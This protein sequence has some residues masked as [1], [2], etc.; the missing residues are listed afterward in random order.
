MVLGFT[1]K[2][3]LIYGTPVLTCVFLL[4]MIRRRPRL[5]HTCRIGTRTIFLVHGI[6]LCLLVTLT[7]I[8]VHDGVRPFAWFLVVTSLFV[9]SVLLGS[10]NTRATWAILFLTVL[11]TAISI[12]VAIYAGNGFYP[13]TWESE[14]IFETGTLQAYQE[15][16]VRAGLYYFVPI[17]T[18]N[19]AAIAF[20][21]GSISFVSMILSATYLAVIASAIFILFRRLHSS[22][23]VVVA[24]A[25]LFFSIPAL[26]V[27]G[28][29]GIFSYAL[30]FMWF[31]LA[32]CRSPLSAFIGILLVGIV[33]IFW[34]PLSIA[35]VI[36]MLLPL[37]ILRIKDWP[38]PGK[39]SKEIAN[40]LLVT[41]VIAF[42][43]WTYTYLLNLGV[44][45]G[46]SFYGTIQSYFAGPAAAGGGEAYVPRYSFSGLEVFAYAWSV[47]I[48]LSVAYF[49]TSLFI[50]LRHR[51]V[52]SE[53][54]T[55]FTS[56]LGPAIVLI[57]Y[58]SYSAGEAG[59]Y[60]IPVGYMVTLLAASACVGVLLAKPGKARR[61]VVLTLI[62]S[63]VLVG[64]Y[65]PDWAPLEHP[66]FESAS[67]LHPYHVYIEAETVSAFLP[68]NVTVYYDYDFPLSGHLYKP[69][70]EVIE[71]VSSGADPVIYASPLSTF[72]G[73]RTER[74]QSVPDW[75][76][77]V[78]YSS[79]FHVVT[80]VNTK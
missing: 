70:R 8:S 7:A 63:V 68:L 75:N 72:F 39:N 4:L 59:Q 31:V 38:I 5:E 56:F 32:K 57:S 42:A 77:D 35:Y 15:G 28:R 27:F 73:M 41:L 26:S 50:L 46:T 36:A 79:G 10:R 23:V 51:R 74:L 11:T 40:P 45:M 78:I 49:L 14:P 64:T 48:A 29:A 53:R 43:Y 44:R 3:M 61:I 22:G 71:A 25:F 55:L 19:G 21:T 37:V 54:M 12:P 13:R 9:T 2:E 58:L 24:G 66:D 76:W 80:M 69:V 65:S 60:M 18:L 16:A 6:L 47:P 34:H 17:E 33:M 1:L 67:Q 30:L 20:G 62:A 52:R